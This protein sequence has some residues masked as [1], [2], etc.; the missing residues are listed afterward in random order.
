[1]ESFSRENLVSLLESLKSA[2]S[3]LRSRQEPRVQGVISR[4]ERRKAEV[5]AAL[6][7][8]DHPTSSTPGTGRPRA[9][10]PTAKTTHAIESTGF[11]AILQGEPRPLVD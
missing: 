2:I 6:A 1:V 7:S 8:K 5:V 4:L 3:E 10:Q 11:G 9:G